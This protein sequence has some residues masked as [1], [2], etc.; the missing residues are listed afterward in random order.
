MSPDGWNEQNTAQS[1]GRR[2]SRESTTPV[3]T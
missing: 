1:S 3:D 2:N